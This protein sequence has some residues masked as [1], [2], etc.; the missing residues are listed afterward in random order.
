MKTTYPVDRR[1][2]VWVGNLPTEDDFDKCIDLEVVP[3]LALPTHIESTCEISFKPKP[4]SVRELIAGFSGG[5]MFAGE[6]A[7]KA[8]ARGISSANAALVVYYVQC[9]D[10]PERWGPLY[11]IGTFVG[12]AGT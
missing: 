7:T 4:V 3:R 2:S 6:A 12:W 1:V 11:F 8:A 10:A 9:E 5:E